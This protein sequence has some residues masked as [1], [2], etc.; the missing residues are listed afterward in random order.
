MDSKTM[1][2]IISQ[3]ARHNCDYRRW[4]DHL[5]E[6]V[7]WNERVYKTRTKMMILYKFVRVLLIKAFQSI[8]VRL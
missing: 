2:G 4:T 1:D 7:I 8:K 3:Y 5:N 6:V